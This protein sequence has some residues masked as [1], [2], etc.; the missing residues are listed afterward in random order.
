MGP[1]VQSQLV[2]STGNSLGLVT[3]ALP[4]GAGLWAEPP[5]RGSVNPGQN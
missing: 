4:V 1:L 2:R 3:L 5:T